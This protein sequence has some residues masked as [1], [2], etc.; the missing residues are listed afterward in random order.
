MVLG[1]SVWIAALI[2]AAAAEIPGCP[3]PFKMPGLGRHREW[4]P[5]IQLFEDIKSRCLFEW[6]CGLL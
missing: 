2:K 1:D 6:L 3:K 5:Q 4:F